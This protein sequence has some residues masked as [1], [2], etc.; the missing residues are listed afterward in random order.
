MTIFHRIILPVEKKRSMIEM[1][2]T[3][4]SW[5][6]KAMS[7]HYQTC[8]CNLLICW[9]RISIMEKKVA[10][11][12]EMW[13]RSSMFSITSKTEN[14]RLRMDFCPFGHKSLKQMAHGVL[15]SQETANLKPRK[16]K[17]WHRPVL[18]QIPRHY[19]FVHYPNENITETNQQSLASGNSQIPRLLPTRFSL[20]LCVCMYINP[21]NK[22]G[23]NRNEREGKE[24]RRRVGVDGIPGD[25]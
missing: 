5:A 11:S 14:Q 19:Y 10:P 13:G 6:E 20:S 9:I 3:L 8:F 7:Y 18:I 12:R 17:P 15:G 2:K 21:G 22:S 16:L 1:I 25:G 24:G 4:P 23:G